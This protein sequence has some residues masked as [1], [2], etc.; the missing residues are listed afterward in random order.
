MDGDDPKA[1][2]IDLIVEVTSR[3]GPAERMLSSLR[4]GGEAAA[5][6]LTAVLD[7]AIEVVDHHAVSS[8]RRS[9][10]SLMELMVRVESAMESID[11][12]WC[13][14]VSGDTSC[15]EEL[16]G[17]MAAVEGL[18]AASSELRDAVSYVSALLD[19]VARCGSVV[20]RSISVLSCSDGDS[21]C[22]L[23]ALEALR[24]LSEARQ[25]EISDEQTVRE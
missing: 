18:A 13:D 24:G 20:L 16:A 10:K 7:H 3:R 1:S 11:T 9:R 5:E 8:P 12:A 22:R 19:C 15:L 21:D 14:S 6:A 2:L 25:T 23:A 17:H 4:A